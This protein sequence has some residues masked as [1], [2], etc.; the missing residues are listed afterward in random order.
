MVSDA[1]A[2]K[3][4]A[5]RCEYIAVFDSL[6]RLLFDA[7]PIGINF[8]TNTDEYEPEVGTIIPRLKHAKSEEDARLIIYEECCRWFDAKTA[9]PIEAYSDIASKAWAEWQ[10]YNEEHLD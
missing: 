7:D 5:V 8:E 4:K 2:E 6:S 9:G 3:R 1:E 10:R